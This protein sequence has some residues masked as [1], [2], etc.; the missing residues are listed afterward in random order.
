MIKEGKAFEYR[1]THANAAN[2]TKKKPLSEDSFVSEDLSDI[3][4]DKNDQ[5]DDLIKKKS[6]KGAV[7]SDI[8]GIYQLL[9]LST[10]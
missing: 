3:C 4:S 5:A 8:K 1:K 9:T 2:T 10:F 6:Q 7:K